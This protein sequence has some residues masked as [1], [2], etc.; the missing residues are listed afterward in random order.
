MKSKTKVLCLIVLGLLS[1][2]AHCLDLGGKGDVELACE[3]VLFFTL[4]LSQDEATKVQTQLMNRDAITGDIIEACSSSECSGGMLGLDNESACR[5]K[6]LSTSGMKIDELRSFLTIPKDSAAEKDPTMVGKTLKEVLFEA[7]SDVVNCKKQMIGALGR[8]DS[9]T[10]S[11]NIDKLVS[12]TYKEKMEPKDID[13]LAA[14]TAMAKSCKSFECRSIIAGLGGAKECKDLLKKELKNASPAP[15]S[16]SKFETM[17]KEKYGDCQEK[18]RNALDVKD[19]EIGPY[20]FEEKSA[21]D[22]ST[23]PGPGQRTLNACASAECA[24]VGNDGKLKDP[25]ACKEK[26]VATRG[27]EREFKIKLNI[28]VDC[29][30]SYHFDQSGSVTVTTDSP[31]ISDLFKNTKSVDDD[32][33]ITLVALLNVMRDTQADSRGDVILSNQD[34]ALMK[35]ALQRSIEYAKTYESQTDDAEILSTFSRQVAFAEDM[36]KYIDGRADGKFSREK[37]NELGSFLEKDKD[38]HGYYINNPEGDLFGVCQEYGMVPRCCDAKEAQWNNVFAKTLCNRNLETGE[39]NTD[40][41][42]YDETMCASNTIQIN[43]QNQGGGTN[44]NE[45]ITAPKN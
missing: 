16:L 24:S 6:I 28:P 32:G 10:I 22:N 38:F 40:V 44:G 26:I 45:A 9:E 1:G 2:Q 37:V 5:D 17:L 13:T 3:D 23:Q 12:T 36:I 21:D 39:P 43:P 8:E 42:R 33:Y 34:A 31:D 4:N 41:F 19:L 11:S 14:V 27:G 25:K 15:L 7:D 29:T 18:I 35:S 30:T 20:F